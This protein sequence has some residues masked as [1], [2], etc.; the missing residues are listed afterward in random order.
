[1]AVV[2]IMLRQ[3]Q[4]RV[5]RRIER[6]G[7]IMS[8]IDRKT[9]SERRV[10][11]AMTGDK[12]KTEMVIPADWVPGPRQGDWTYEMYAALPEDGQRYEVVQGVLMMSPAPETAHQGVIQ[13]I[14]H[15]LDE[16]NFSTER[17]LVFTSPV[18]VVLSSQQV[19]QPDVLVLLEE[20]LDRLQ[21][22]CIMGPPDLVV[23]V[24]LPGSITYDRVVKHKLYEEAGVPEY[25]LVNLQEQSLEVFVLEEGEYRSLGAFRD[26]QEV[27]SRLIPRASVPAAQLFRWTG[28]LR[29]G[30]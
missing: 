17:G 20:H 24:I 6:N 18:D 29:T 10:A 25:W 3:Q 5:I 22:K 1:M 19:V 8:V 4:E 12:N 30:K 11:I 23:E 15:Y 27:Q 2:S 7:I 13:R 9:A 14:S 21:E 28:H 26:K 16:Q